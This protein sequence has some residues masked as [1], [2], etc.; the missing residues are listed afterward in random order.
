MEISNYLPIIV[1][2]K[3]VA[4]FDTGGTGMTAKKHAT[5]KFK[6]CRKNK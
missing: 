5:T 6:T 4:E 3:V 1:L 2:E